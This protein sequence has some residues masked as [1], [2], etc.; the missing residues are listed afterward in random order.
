MLNEVSMG[1]SMDRAYFLGVVRLEVHFVSRVY[2]GYWQVGMH[3]RYLVLV[4]R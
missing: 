1:D 3:R 2:T 4:M